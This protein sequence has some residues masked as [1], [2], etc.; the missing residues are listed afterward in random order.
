MTAPVI[1]FWLTL[2]ALQTAPAPSAQP[3]Q[4]AAPQDQQAAPAPSS[5][6]AAPR[7][8]RRPCRNPDASGN[9]RVGCGVTPPK[10]IHLADPEFSELARKQKIG[11]D[12]LVSLTVDADGSPTNIKVTRSL[13]DKVD[14]KFRKAALSLDDKAIEAVSKYRFAPATY[15]GSPVAV[16]VNVDVNF[17]IF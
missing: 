9:Y 15:Q 14:P 2:F 17:Q 4:T 5:D 8:A 11:G 3:T 7:P 10:P 12:V 6:E 16:Q 13:A 1:T